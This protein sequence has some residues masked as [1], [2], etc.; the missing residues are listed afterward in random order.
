MVRFHPWFSSRIRV[1]SRVLDQELMWPWRK[2]YKIQ[3]R[4]QSGTDTLSSHAMFH[5]LPM[6]MSILL[7]YS[8]KHGAISMV[9]WH[10]WLSNLHVK[11]SVLLVKHQSR[12]VSLWG[13]VRCILSLVCGQ[14]LVKIYHL[15][16]NL[17]FKCLCDTVCLH[18]DI[19]CLSLPRLNL[20]CFVFEWKTTL[21]TPFFFNENW[22]TKCFWEP[23]QSSKHVCETNEKECDS[24]WHVM[25]NCKHW[26]QICWSFGWCSHQLACVDC[27]A[28]KRVT[29]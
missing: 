24:K 16:N 12:K 17:G 14:I 15:S 6:K 13:V 22:M 7:E 8:I 28:K 21:C 2:R 10:L 18:H 25:S 29:V 26:N 20:I 11:A 27:K 9:E 3:S 4:T 1:V 23:T 19:A 5:H